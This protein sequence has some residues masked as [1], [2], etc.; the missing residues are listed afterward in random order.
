MHVSAPSKVAFIRMLMTNVWGSVLTG[1]RPLR[2]RL[3]Q[4]LEKAG[5]RAGSWDGV[6]FSKTSSTPPKG[7]CLAL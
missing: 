3:L 1:T 7:A 5:Q 6:I 2:R 4:L